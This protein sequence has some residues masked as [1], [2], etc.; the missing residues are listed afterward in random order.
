[1]SSK[2]T[3]AESR[4][5][6]AEGRGMAVGKVD[7]VA[8]GKCQQKIKSRTGWHVRG[9]KAKGGGGKGIPGTGGAPGKDAPGMPG[10]T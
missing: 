9:G 8:L 5:L 1:M 3:Y 2:V 6:L 4:R 7:Q 10:I